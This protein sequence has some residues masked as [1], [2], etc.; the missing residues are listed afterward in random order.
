MTRKKIINIEENYTQISRDEIN[1]AMN[2]FFSEGGKIQKIETVHN[3]ITT[4]DPLAEQEG[5]WGEFNNLNFS[6]GISSLTPGS[7]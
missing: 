2:R 5:N 3:S 6:S 7:W 4:I 1:E